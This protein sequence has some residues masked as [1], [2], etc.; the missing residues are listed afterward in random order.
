[1]PK[2]EKEKEKYRPHHSENN[3]ELADVAAI[4]ALVRG[5]ADGDQQRRALKWI[6]EVA[7]RTYDLPYFDDDRDTAFAC[8]KMFVGQ[9]IRKL[10]KFDL[11]ELGKIIEARKE[12]IKKNY[13]PTR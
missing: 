8:G 4:Q 1:M 9:E 5:D 10:T 11:V 13:Q 6:V 3:Y 12:R 2:K 7:C